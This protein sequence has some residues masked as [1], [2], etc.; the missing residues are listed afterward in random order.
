MKRVQKI[1]SDRFLALFGLAVMKFTHNGFGVILH[2][3]MVKTQKM[4][5]TDSFF[6]ACPVINTLYKCMYFMKQRYIFFGQ[7]A[8]VI[9][10]V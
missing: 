6:G 10:N 3:I 5:H 2:I 7:P 4:R 9:G 8:P 1:F